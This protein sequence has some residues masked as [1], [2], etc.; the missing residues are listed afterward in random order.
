[1]EAIAEETPLDNDIEANAKSKA[2]DKK[3]ETENQEEDEFGA[4]IIKD[5]QEKDKPV[6]DKPPKYNTIRTEPLQPL[7]KVQLARFRRLDRKINQSIP[8]IHYVG[9][10]THGMHLITDNTQGAFCR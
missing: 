1:M 10:I 6:S 9:Q 3:A 4:K 2:G 8:E 5:D 7:N